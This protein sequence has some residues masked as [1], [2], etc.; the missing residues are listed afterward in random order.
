MDYLI[1]V[2]KDNMIENSYFDG[3]EL[4]ECKNIFGEA[5]QVEKETYRA[6]VELKKFLETKDIHIELDSAYRS[7]DEQQKIAAEFT[8]KYG[9]EYVSK[10][11]APV[12]TSEHHT[13]LALDIGLIIN[14]KEITEEEKL[15][16][17]KNTYLEIH[18]YLSDF[19]FILRYPKDKE[20]ITGYNYEPWHIRYV[21]IEKAKEITENN[22][23]LEEYVLENN[24][25]LL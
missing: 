10:Y 22:L 3:L 13:G 1:L 12:G 2:N 11:V 15:I 7:I 16:V 9:E 6:Y 21:G 18:K 24:K 17:K 8:E 5:I 20:N 19:G 25:V 23:T 14:D 4:V